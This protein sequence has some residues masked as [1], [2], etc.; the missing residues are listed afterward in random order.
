[1]ETT[2]WFT[3]TARQFNRKAHVTQ[4]CAEA[5]ATATFNRMKPWAREGVDPLG[6]V[7]QEPTDQWTVFCKKC[8]VPS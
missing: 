2:A 4:A 8:E 6:G 1:M 5:T 7:H 3:A